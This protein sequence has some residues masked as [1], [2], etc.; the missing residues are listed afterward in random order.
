MD[1][2]QDGWNKALWA[3]AACIQQLREAQVADSVSQPNLL[4]VDQVR[5]AIERLS[6]DLPKSIAGK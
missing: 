3:A 1:D 4:H 2:Y 6:L 5:H